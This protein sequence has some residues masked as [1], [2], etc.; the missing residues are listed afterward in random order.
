MKEVLYKTIYDLSTPYEIL[1]SIWHYFVSA[2]WLVMAGIVFG[3]IIS[4]AVTAFFGRR[5]FL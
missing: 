1:A 2:S 3:L 5:W 4:I